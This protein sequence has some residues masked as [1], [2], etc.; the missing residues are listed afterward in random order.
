MV[1][2]PKSYK[3]PNNNDLLV[4]KRHLGILNDAAK[5]FKTYFVN[6]VVTYCTDDKKIDVYFSYSN[7]MHLCGIDYEK[8]SHSFFND[9]FSNKIVLQAIKIKKDGTTL[10]KL[11]TLTSI[12]DLIGKHVRLV[13]RG[14]YLYLSFD[15]ALRTNKQILALTLLND[16]HKIV[17]QSLL[18]LK[19]QKSFPKGD[20]VRC[21]YAKDLST[22][23]KTIHVNM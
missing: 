2:Y 14:T 22:H 16:H 7:F 4:L 21:I 15:Y 10:Q 11:Q 23:E 20:I 17:P 8:G 3:K 13:T 12:R 6:Q 9:C 1:K 19:R 18:N 5:F